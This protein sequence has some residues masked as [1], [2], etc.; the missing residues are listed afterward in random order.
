MEIQPINTE[1]VQDFSSIKDGESAER[2]P[3]R[4]W[5]ARPVYRKSRTF[6]LKNIRH[7][8]CAIISVILMLTI[9]ASSAGAA[10]VG[11]RVYRA[12][13]HQIE[14]FRE[15]AAVNNG[16]LPAE[17]AVVVRG[18][19]GGFLDIMRA[20]GANIPKPD[21]SSSW[22]RVFVDTSDYNKRGQ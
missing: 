7:I 2:Q 18:L 5:S 21:R 3:V 12:V 16:E 13:D 19:V 17:K 15:L 8:A 22:S 6:R 1:N 11:F 9:L 14:P 10:Y 4:L 20:T